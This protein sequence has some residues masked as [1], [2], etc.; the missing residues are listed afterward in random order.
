[1]GLPLSGQLEELHTGPFVAIDGHP[2]RCV[3]LGHA[4]HPGDP[5]DLLHLLPLFLSGLLFLLS[6][7]KCNLEKF[8]LQFC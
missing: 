4:D 1:M 3:R 5:F 2:E 6:Q 8:D 7:F